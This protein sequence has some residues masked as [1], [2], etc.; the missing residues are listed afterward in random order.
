MQENC[1]FFCSLIQQHLEG[2]GEGWFLN[3]SAKYQSLAHDI[4]VRISSRVWQGRRS[5]MS[6]EASISSVPSP[7]PVAVRSG[8]PQWNASNPT[9]SPLPSTD[10]SIPP[11]SD[12]DLML[13]DLP[14]SEP[15]PSKPFS[16]PQWPGFDPEVLEKLNGLASGSGAKKEQVARCA[17]KCLVS[18]L[19]RASYHGLSRELSVVVPNLRIC[20]PGSARLRGSRPR[21]SSG[22]LRP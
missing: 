5:G 13:R 19:L 18:M 11:P 10:P 16:P 14:T 9:P 7:P 2:A 12:I 4:R 17:R 1:W 21:S 8:S 6:I 20:P 22:V 3:G 15:A